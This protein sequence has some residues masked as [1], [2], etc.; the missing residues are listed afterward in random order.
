MHKEDDRVMDVFP[1]SMLV[2]NERSRAFKDLGRRILEATDA[3][4]FD[5]P[6]DEPTEKS[7]HVTNILFRTLHWTPSQYRDEI[8][9]LEKEL[10]EA[11]NG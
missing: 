11:K 5:I 10:E 6:L 3:G 8:Y 2:M 1:E 4:N 9:R 7:V